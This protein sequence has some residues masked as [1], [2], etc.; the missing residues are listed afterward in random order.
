MKSLNK[1]LALG[2][3]LGVSMLAGATVAN[4]T[5][6]NFDDLGSGCCNAVPNGYNGFNFVNFGSIDDIHHPG[7]GYDLG[8]ISAHNT[9]FNLFGDPAQ[10]GL[11]NTASSFTLNSFYATAAWTDGLTLFLE[12]IDNG[13]IIHSTSVKLSNIVASLV[14]LNWG[15]IDTFRISTSDNSQVAFDNVAVNV[16]SVPVPGALPLLATGLV[17]IA[18]LRRRNKRKAA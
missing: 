5:I 1:N 14:T 17:G 3:F 7:S 2:F 10:F 11:A 18:A 9:M 12:G 4:A 13:S 6:M 16:S 15:G 8:T